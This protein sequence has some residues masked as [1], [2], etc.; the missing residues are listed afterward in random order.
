MQAKLALRLCREEGLLQFITEFSYDAFQF[1]TIASD[2]EHA[3]CWMRKVHRSVFCIK[4]KEGSKE[5]EV[6]LKDPKKH[7]AWGLGRK[8]T[9]EGSDE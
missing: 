8:M 2:L 9:L 1:C 4:G 3:K 5:Y 6:Y 7:R